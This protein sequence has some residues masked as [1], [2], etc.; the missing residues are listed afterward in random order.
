M[1]KERNMRARIIRSSQRYFDCQILA[2]EEI[3]IYG[4]V[5]KACALGNLL[6]GENSIVVGD[7]VLLE[8]V[9]DSSERGKIDDENNSNIEYKIKN[10]ETRN[11]QIFRIIQR[12]S[13][14]KV[15]AANC[16]Y[17]VIVLAVSKPD[18]KRGVL[19][20]FLVRAEEWGIKPIFVINKMDQYKNDVDILFERDRLKDLSI[21]IFEVSAKEGINYKCNFINNGIVELFD[22]LKG[23]TALFVG[24]S[25]VG[26]SKLITKLIEIGKSDGKKE[27]EIDVDGILDTIRVGDIRKIGKGSHTTTWAQLIDTGYFS[28][29][30]S[31]GIRS[32]AMD[33][34][35]P[36]EL[37]NF[38]P[39]L[40]DIALKCQFPNCRHDNN[41]KGC[42]FENL[43]SKLGLKNERDS[44]LIQSRLDSYLKIYE[45][46]SVIPEWQKDIR[47]KSKKS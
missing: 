22:L 47:P 39:D 27:I 29:I 36:K 45:E 12:E 13:K 11:N 17:L 44:M 37:I 9:L 5:V 28:L 20:R 24:P 31:P 3:N 16:D 26:K 43:I 41:S 46:A 35:D 42:A 7:Y 8:G 32:F 18:Y 30:D 40:R 14:I 6:K 23:K 25:G 38:F 4:K 34:I 10:V 15:I 2:N 33:D 1:E 21:D 19:D